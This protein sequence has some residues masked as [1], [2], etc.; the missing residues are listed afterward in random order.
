MP[1]WSVKVWLSDP[2]TSRITR[3]APDTAG[4]LAVSGRSKL[5]E[6][7]W[8]TNFA[9]APVRMTSDRPGMSSSASSSA[10]AA[11]GSAASRASATP[12]AGRTHVMSP[13]P[14]ARP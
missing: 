1:A 8:Q 2:P 6:A 7:G 14:P 9:T 12:T 3:L 11:Y 4:S 5:P 10:M 13:F